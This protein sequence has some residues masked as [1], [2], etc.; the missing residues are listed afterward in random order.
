MN[1]F[2]YKPRTRH[3]VVTIDRKLHKLD[4][5]F[6][7]FKIKTSNLARV[8]MNELPFFF[9]VRVQVKLHNFNLI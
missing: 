7:L 4:I 8:I 2:I 6:Y 1:V 5:I 9:L 3:I